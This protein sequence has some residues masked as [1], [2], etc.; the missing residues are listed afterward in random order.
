VGIYASLEIHQVN[1]LGRAKS[2]FTRPSSPL[3]VI[4]A[5]ATSGLLDSVFAGPGEVAEAA[6][7]ILFIEP[8]VHLIF[9]LPIGGHARF[10]VWAGMW[11]VLGRYGSGG[12]VLL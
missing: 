5:V 9:R 7:G 8:G 1:W 2:D 12:V 11:S 10:S 3:T 6:F 4:R